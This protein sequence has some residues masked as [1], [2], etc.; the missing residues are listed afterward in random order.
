MNALAGTIVKGLKQRGIQTFLTLLLFITFASYIP[1][2]VQQGFYSISLFIKDILLWLMP[3]T[4]CVF[5]ANTVHSFERRA[6]I[7]ILV[8]VLFETVSNFSSVWYAF[9]GAHLVADH[10]PVI[11]ATT[12]STDFSPLW[13][14]P[15]GKPAWWSAEKGSFIGLAIGCLAAF[16]NQPVLNR[17]VTSGKN[18]MEWLLTR[19]FSRLI[20]F[21]ILGFAAQMYQTKLLNHVFTH[22]AMLTVWLLVFLSMYMLFL[23]ALGAGFS[24]Q[25]ILS[26][27]KN[28]LPA[29]GIALTSG[30]SLS[31]MP[32]TI[33]GAAKNLE[34]PPLA[35]AIIPATTNIQQIGDC[36]TNA[37]LVFLIYRHFNGVNPD[38]VTWAT[39]SIVF[40]LARFATA[41]VLGGA[42]FIMLPIYETY[43][44]FNPAMIGIILAL[45][46]FLDPIVTSSNVMANGAL[47]RVFEKVWRR[48]Q[49]SE[50][51]TTKSKPPIKIFGS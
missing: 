47:C 3:I 25:R 16:S 7:F 23:F 30:C 5:I 6:P 44:D 37:F 19:V 20:P 13:R 46:V 38:L 18:A 22:Y 1:Y 29:G 28:L 40:V 35:K 8:L 21:F 12:F 14:L 36:I 43:L 48:F 15:F 33:D 45:N 17:V 42:I 2:Q 9:G 11:N 24:W 49:G 34:N 31:T 32:W 27:L 26:N 10:L 51:E 50:V 39:F 4:A 41:A